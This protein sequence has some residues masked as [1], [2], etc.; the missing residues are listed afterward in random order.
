MKRVTPAQRRLLERLAK[1][2]S[3]ASDGY[4]TWIH[5]GQGPGRTEQVLIRLHDRGLVVWDGPIDE[6]TITDAGRAALGKTK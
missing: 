3:V 1:G 5:A 6:V 2:Q 4:E